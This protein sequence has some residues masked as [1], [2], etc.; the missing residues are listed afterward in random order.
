M[1]DVVQNTSSEKFVDISCKTP[2]GKSF[3]IEIELL[4]SKDQLVIDNEY[5]LIVGSQEKAKAICKKMRLDADD[6]AAKMP[7]FYRYFPEKWKLD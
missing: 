4:N 3:K 7:G 2:K 6:R 5:T 1:I